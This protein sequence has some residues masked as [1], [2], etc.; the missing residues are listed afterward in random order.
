MRTI[1][2]F[3]VFA[4]FI[5]AAMGCASYSNITRSSSSRSG[6]DAYSVPVESGSKSCAICGGRGY[7]IRNGVKETCKPCSGTG[8]AVS[9]P[10]K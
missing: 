5:L 1:L 9:F 7:T 8:K 10:E 3:I 6:W 2:S 4:F